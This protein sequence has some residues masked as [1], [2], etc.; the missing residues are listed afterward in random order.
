MTAS[1]VNTLYC[2]YVVLPMK[3]QQ[4]LHLIRRSLVASRSFSSRS[5]MSTPKINNISPLPANEAKWTELR[6]IEVMRNRSDCYMAEV[7]TRPI[8][9]GLIKYDHVSWC[10]SHWTNHLIVR[11]RPSMGSSSAQDTREIRCRRSS[12]CPDS[13]TSK[14]A[15]VDYGD[16]AVPPTG[17]C[18]VR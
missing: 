11:Q 7:L 2:Q 16:P 17:R 12:N 18:R 10:I 5:A 1:V 14:Q 8:Y 15:T 4:R 13:A 6:K 9:S 3:A